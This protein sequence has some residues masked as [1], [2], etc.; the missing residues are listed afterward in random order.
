M[1]GGTASWTYPRYV[2]VKSLRLT[3]HHVDQVVQADTPGFHP[4]VGGSIPSIRTDDRRGGT[5]AHGLAVSR[6]SGENVRVKKVFSRG[7]RQGSTA[8]K[9]AR[10]GSPDPGSIPGYST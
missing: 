5:L 6:A 8:I 1:W 2:K 9:T 4:G 10:G 7:V 3:V